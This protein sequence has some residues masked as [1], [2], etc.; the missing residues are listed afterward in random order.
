M[1]KRGCQLSIEWGSDPQG[2][3]KSDMALRLTGSGVM[4]RR[5]HSS[6][7]IEC[8]C[9]ISIRHSDAES[10]WRV[11]PRGSGGRHG[12][13]GAHSD[14]Y[15]RR[16]WARGRDPFGCQCANTVRKHR[17]TNDAAGFGNAR[18]LRSTADKYQ[19]TSVDLHA[20][21]MGSP[22]SSAAGRGHSSARQS[23]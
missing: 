3:C 8:E 2:G 20:G 9:P 11:A 5:H 23:G 12:A 16:V 4:P 22:P 1:V 14:A 13:R 18:C 6:G 10:A 21:L 19:Y 7:A 17:T 15:H